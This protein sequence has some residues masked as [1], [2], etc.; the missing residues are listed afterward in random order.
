MVGQLE[1]GPCL[2]P[3]TAYLDIIAQCGEPSHSH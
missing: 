1:T 3:T 2:E